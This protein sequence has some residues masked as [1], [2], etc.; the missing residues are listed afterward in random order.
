MR[1]RLLAASVCLSSAA[2]AAPTVNTPTGQAD[3]TFEHI[4]LADAA[5]KVASACMD[6]GWQITSQ[7]TNTVTCQIPFSGFKQALAGALL[8][9]A[10]ST[11]P[12]IYAQFS[13]AQIGDSTR[14][15]A[16]AWMETQ[17]AF[18]QMRRMDY[19]DAKTRTNLMVFLRPVVMRDAETTNRLSVDRYE[20]IR[21]FQKEMQPTPSVLVPINESPVIAPIRHADEPNNQLS[22]PQSSPGTTKPLPAPPPGD[23]ALRP[24]GET[25][26]VPVVV[27]V[28]VAPVPP[29]PAASAAGG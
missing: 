13:M 15:Q 24:Q 19:K 6:K 23:A 10:Y 12:N 11:P 14:A 20:Q 18:G 22:A 16:H 25:T 26:P 21:G 28:I 8:G 9:N 3:V 1:K 17:M 27:L 5:G 2:M 29:T 7:T 4:D